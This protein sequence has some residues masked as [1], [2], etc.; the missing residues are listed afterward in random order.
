MATDRLRRKL[1]DVSPDTLSTLTSSLCIV[2]TPLPFLTS[3]KKDQNE[4]KPIWQQEARNAQGRRRFHGAFTGGW[5]AGYFNTVGSKEG[6]TPG[7]FRSSRKDRAREGMGS[8]AEDFM[9]EE[10]MED[11][12]GAQRVQASGSLGGINQIAGLRDKSDPLA[13]TFGG[14]DVGGTNGEDVGF[15][16]MRRM[17]WKSGHGLGPR[18]DAKKRARLLRLISTSDG[19]S[20]TMASSSDIT[21]EDM[22]QLYDPP[23]TPFPPSTTT[24]RG[25]KGLGADVSPTLAKVLSS[26]RTSSAPTRTTMQTSEDVWPDGRPILSGFH[27][28]RKPSPPEPTFPSPPVPPGWQADPSRVLQRYAPSPDSKAPPPNPSRRGQLLGEA[29]IP[30]PAPNI[31][32]FLSSKARERL[33]S[34][35][36]ALLPQS[37]SAPSPHV[38]CPR[39]D[40]ATARQALAGFAPFST[41]PAKQ[42]RY[43]SYLQSQLDATPRLPVPPELTVE[44][45]EVELKDFARSATMFRPMSGAFASRFTTAS[46]NETGDAGGSGLRQPSS[47]A[48]GEDTVPE[49]ER[50]LSTAE[51]AAKMGNFGHLTRKVESW[52]PERL[53]CKRFGVAEPAV[54][55]RGRADESGPSAQ[56]DQDDPQ[57]PFYGTTKSTR[58]KSS[59][60]VD[61]HWARNKQHLMALAA[62]PTPLSL[63]LAPSQTPL[64]DAADEPIVGLGN[65]DGQDDTLTYV[66]PPPDVYKSIFADSDAEDTASPAGPKIQH[67]EAGSGSGVIFQARSKRKDPGDG[68]PEKKRKKDKSKRALLTFDLDDGDDGGVGES[69]PP[70]SKV[71]ARMRASD[72]F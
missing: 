20:G 46:Q 54:S 27:L 42:S 55:R 13:A 38:D 36:A 2:G 29:P 48:A 68:K 31:A 33:A 39:I 26:N 25:R 32:A 5:S 56:P 43:V 57:D 66:K 8:R 41:I 7:S 11:W 40:P 22:Q 19:D 30:G 70:K 37:S 67:P 3:S 64:E 65:D 4:L 71:G 15:K 51:Q 52:A 60:Q 17:G 12:K 24:Q 63:D 1:R 53:L 10:D 58:S 14:E 16:L 59:V 61:Q 18:I 49:R 72:L 28:A 34:T 45:F 6:W 50:E 35:S 69:A 23:P 9:D 44:Q 21:L 62:G 47:S